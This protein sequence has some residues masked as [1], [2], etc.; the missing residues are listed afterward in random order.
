LK[1][2]KLNAIDSTNSFLKELAQTTT[3]ESYTV[4]VTK[5]QKN[6]RGQQAQKWF[7]EPFKNLTTS[8]YISNIDLEINKQK[9]LN[10]AISLA[11]F[12]AL[13]IHQ[14]K[15]LSIKWPND[16][17]SV[18]KKICGI[19]IENTIKGSK[20]QSSIV[21]IGLNVNQEKFPDSLKNASSLKNIAQKEF[22]LDLLLVQIIEKIQQRIAMVSLKEYDALETAYLNVL[23]K[24]NIPTMFKD[25]NDV[26]FMGK[27]TGISFSGNLQ[28]ELEDETLK[29]FRIKEVSLA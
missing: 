19:L 22:D 27:I 18:N 26:L 2:I 29:E 6:G 28:I 1:I 25:S 14:I 3:L 5:E 24:K 15:N 20:I 17:L 11:I 9:Y 13:S 23:Y 12:D 8:V 4:V 16:I 7:S 10:F 21:G